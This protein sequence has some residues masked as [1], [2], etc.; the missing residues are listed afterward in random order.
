MAYQSQYQQDP[1]PQEGGFFK[2]EH[3]RRFRELPMERLKTVQF[4]DCAEKPGISNDYSVCMTW[5]QTLSG[6]YAIDRFRER[7]AF[8]EL[9]RA[10]LDQYNQHKPHAVVIEDKSAG[11]QLIQNLKAKTT[12]PILPYQ[13]GV[14]SKEVRAGGAVPTQEAGNLYLPDQAAWAEEFILEHERF[15]NVEH[16]DQVDTTS[17]MVE[18]FKQGQAPRIRR[19]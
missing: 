11:T 5:V 17:M 13:P 8:P 6:F 16:D 1:R 4:W 3:W 10:C 18:H 12:L 7:V 14:N 15:P 2:R 19:L 9:E